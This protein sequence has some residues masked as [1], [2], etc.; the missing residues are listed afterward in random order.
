M[1]AVVLYAQ[2]DRELAGDEGK[3]ANGLHNVLPPTEREGD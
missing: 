2:D 3:L 1:S